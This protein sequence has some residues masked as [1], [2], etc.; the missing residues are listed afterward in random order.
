MVLLR[1]LARE[2]IQ[3]A[4]IAV[5]CLAADPIDQGAGMKIL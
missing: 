5:V 1:P 2:V 3:Q 4:T